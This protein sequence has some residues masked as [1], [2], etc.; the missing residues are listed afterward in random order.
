MSTFLIFV[1]EELFKS[2]HTNP[3]KLF[4]L[5]YK[6]SIKVLSQLA[7]INVKKFNAKIKHNMQFHANFLCKSWSCINVI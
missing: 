3:L 7:L 1:K 2:Y 6:Q 4:Y 5:V